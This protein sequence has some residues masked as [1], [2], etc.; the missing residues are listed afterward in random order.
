MFLTLENFAFF[1]E[2]ES[3]ILFKNEEQNEPQKSVANDLKR[4]N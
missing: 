4:P 3:G 2:G 1:F